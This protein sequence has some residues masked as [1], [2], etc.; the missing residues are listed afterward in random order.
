MAAGKMRLIRFVSLAI[1]LTFCNTAWSQ[2]AE[3]LDR[4]LRQ[5]NHRIFTPAEGAP[6]DISALAQTLDGTLWIGGRTGLT[7]FDG[8]RFVSYPGSSDEPLQ[9]TNVAS[10]LATPDGGLWIG[11]RPSGIALLKHG[12]VTRY[13]M[14]DGLPFGTVQQLAQDRDGSIWAAARLGLVRFDGARWETVADRPELGT[15]YGVLVDPAGTLWVAA[16]DGLFARPS[17]ENHFREVD[18]RVYSN[19]SGV[20]IAPAADGRIWA[21]AD[22]AL[23]HVDGPAGPPGGAAL[24]V[25]GVT[26]GPVLFDRA[27]SLWAS[28]GAEK[29]L[30]RVPARDLARSGEIDALARAEKSPHTDDL[31]SGRVFA[32]LEDRESNVWVGTNAG[33]HRFSRSNV[34]R[35]AVPTCLQYEFA[36]GAFAAGDDGTL[37]IACA[38]AA[39]PHVAEI[40]D[41]E[42]VS[43]QPSLPFTVAYRDAQGTVWFAGPSALAHLDGRKIVPTSLPPDVSGRAVQSLLRDRSGAMWISITR[44]G[45]FRVVDGEWTEN[46]GLDALPSDFAYVMAEDGDEALWL[47]YTD[48]RIARVSGKSVQMF[49]AADGLDVGNVLAVLARGREIW[50]GGELGFARFDG[51]RFVS[52]RST[53]GED[54]EG[55]SGIVKARNG[56]LWLNGIAGIARI[57][58]DEIDRVLE[59]PDHR[60][61]HETFDYLDGVPGAAVQLRPQPSAVETTD[62][63]IWFST[64]GG[65]V[66]IDATQIV[67]N[68][69]PPPVTVWALTSGAKRYPNVGAPLELPVHSTEIQIEYGAGSLTVPERVRFRYK[70]EG[71]DREWHDAGNRREALY[72]NLGPGRYTFRLTASNNDGVWNDSGASIAFTIAPAFYQTWWFYALCALACAALLAALYRARML[73]VAAQVRGRLEARLAERERIARE[74]HDTLLQG[75]QGLIWRFQAAT[76][77]LAPG[78]P[79]RQM[80]EQSLDRADQLLGESRDKVKDLRPMAKDVTDLAAALA[81]EGAQLAETHS[82]NFT[83]SVEGTYRPL[84]PIVREEGFLIA[85]EALCNAFRH[86]RADE[87]EAEVSYDNSVLHIRIRDDGRG[88]GTNILDGG[89]PGHFGLIG[90]RERAKRLGAHLD[91]WSRPGAGT[92]VDLAVPAQVAYGRSDTGSG[93][94]PRHSIFSLF[95][96]EH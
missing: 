61:A 94:R 15:P 87:I 47:G 42:V 35:G 79:A 81:G 53:A 65:I 50:V 4:T 3:H 36:A 58:R 69:L 20:V 60:V 91:V 26:G 95:A 2:S 7:R 46:G 78:E 29:S 45:T 37:W 28:A 52:I 39:S 23:M 24:T 6:S 73:Q 80:L 82:A 96:R 41:G 8:V 93:D 59:Y 40:R 22:D 86:A 12:R 71:L 70:L 72:A 19:P 5:L 10:L 85:R 54:F 34:V 77:R 14:K 32:L 88:I 90:M 63:N 51:Q 43:R 89:R 55:V 56:D 68:S 76:D 66:S 13:D 9:A 25:A 27:G 92:E 30:I 21:A 16:F 64:T 18:R 49:S 67:R 74:L 1:S 62:G 75:M 44:R 33:L 84:H 57:D 83:V 31:R 48:S 17:G 11:F 38:D